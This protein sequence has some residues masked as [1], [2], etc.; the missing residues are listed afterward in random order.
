M[1]FPKKAE[2]GLSPKRAEDG[3]GHAGTSPP[4]LVPFP[5]PFL[6]NCWESEVLS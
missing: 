5:V 2:G 4:R 3:G 1:T 6:T